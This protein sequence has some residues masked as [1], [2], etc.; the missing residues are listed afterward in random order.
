MNRLRAGIIGLAVGLYLGDALGLW[1]AYWWLYGLDTT[2]GVAARLAV[3]TA[4]LQP[5]IW[6]TVGA[7]LA[8]TLWPVPESS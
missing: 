6:G 5:I 8:A 7:L 4:R 1:V 3:D 2:A